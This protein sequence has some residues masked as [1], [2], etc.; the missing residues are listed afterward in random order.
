MITMVKC[1]HRARAWLGKLAHLRASYK[2]R[3][4]RWVFP[5]VT[6]LICFRSGLQSSRAAT[7]LASGHEPFLEIWFRRY[8]LRPGTLETFSQ[9][10]ADERP[11][12]F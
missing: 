10:K 4:V 7:L 11:T 9:S 8:S 2:F 6:R 12:T 1:V 3:H 5:F